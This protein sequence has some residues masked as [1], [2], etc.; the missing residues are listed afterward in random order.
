MRF[1]AF[2]RTPAEDRHFP[3]PLSEFELLKS[4]YDPTCGQQSPT[5]RTFV[6]CS[7]CAA[8]VSE[9]DTDEHAAWHESLSAAQDVEQQGDDGE[10]DQ[11]GGQ[12][13]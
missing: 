3:L 4:S 2:G 13:G 8:V 1:Q 6:R 11:N 7:T 10:D 12:H 9:W 5:I